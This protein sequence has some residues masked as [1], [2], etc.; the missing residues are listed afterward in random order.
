[1][2]K[3]DLIEALKRSSFSEC[4]TEEDY[5]IYEKDGIYLFLL[6]SSL[7]DAYYNPSWNID[8]QDIKLLRIRKG[9]VEIELADGS[10]VSLS[11]DEEIEIGCMG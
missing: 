9:Y 4:E 5:S 1:M 7:R 10:S 11:T 8:Y 3:E 2:E 6:D